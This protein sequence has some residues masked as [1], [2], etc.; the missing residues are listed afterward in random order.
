MQT[1]ILG[2]GIIGMTIAFRLAKRS[3]GSDSIVIVGSQLRDKAAT[4]AAPA[5]LN[6]FAE[7]EKDSLVSEIDL[8][9]FELSRE[10]TAIWPAFEQEI[11]RAAYPDSN[12]TEPKIKPFDSGTYVVNNT[13]TDDLD[14]E[15]FDAIVD[16]LKRYDE[17]FSDVSPKDIPNY[18][19]EQRYR[20]TRAIYIDGEGWVNP[21]LL[22]SKLEIALN[23]LGNVAFIDATA[24]KLN[25]QEKK[26]SSVELDNNETIVGDDFVLAT[27]ATVTDLLNA[28]NL[29]I[30]VPRIFY[31]IGVSVEIKS[32]D[33][34]HT[35]CVRTPNRGLA[36]G[37]Y[38]APYIASEHYPKDHVIVGASNF[39]SP[40]PYHYGRLTSVE[41]LV[42][43]AIEQ[44][45][46]NFY[47]ADFIRANVGWRPTSQDTYP[48]MGKTSI[49]NLVIVT[50][51]KREG[52][53]LAPVISQ[54]IVALLLN[55]LVEEQFN[56][57]KPERDVIKSLTREEAIAKA[58]RHQMSAAYQHGFNPSKSRMP[59]QIKQMYR[60]NLEKLHDQVGAIDW[61]IPP[62]M[63]DM[64]KYGHAIA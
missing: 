16:A 46:S 6:S 21:K 4:F 7:V 62:E 55:E 61:G 10:A 57:F 54:K 36:C 18:M 14:D 64:Y 31:G 41:G 53:H 32:P 56:L 42:R 37:L 26:I 29:P 63:L 9:R 35:K 33:Y 25:F 15:S 11:N 43:G 38:S 8:Y 1:I 17:P 34:V 19:P 44:I 13:A 60:D 23:N 40:T 2:N 47:R 3:S 22:I 24:T 45:N 58:V 39:I 52:F 49:S 51:T 27:G 48:L 59:E 12:G 20:A 28:S 30:K 50:G 5:M